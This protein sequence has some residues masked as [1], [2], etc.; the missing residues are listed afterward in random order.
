MA[1]QQIRYLEHLFFPLDYDLSVTIPGLIRKLYL[2]VFVVTNTSMLDKKKSAFRHGRVCSSLIQA[3]HR[4]AHG[5]CSCLFKNIFCKVIGDLDSIRL[6][7]NVF[8]YI[9]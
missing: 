4:R 1:L 8:E 7:W 6:G 9:F 5:I 3:R 2:K